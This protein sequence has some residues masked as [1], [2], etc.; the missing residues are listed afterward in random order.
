MKEATLVKYF[1]SISINFNNRNSTTTEL[2]GLFLLVKFQKCF[3]LEIR[4]SI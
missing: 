3:G 2:S 1:P 4:N